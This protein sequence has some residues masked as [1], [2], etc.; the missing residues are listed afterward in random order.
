MAR[1]YAQV[2]TNLWTE[3][4]IR[5]LNKTQQRAYLL[6]LTQ[7]ELSR[8][9]V[10]PYRLKRLAALAGDDNP[11]S[12]RKDLKALAK[13]RHL[14]IDED[15]EEILVRTYVRHDGLLAQPQIVATMVDD[16]QLIE[17]PTLRLAF[18]AELRRI[19]DLEL[20]DNQRRGLALALGD[21]THTDARFRAKIGLGLAP[22]MGAAF[23]A[24]SLPPFDP[25]C[26]A[27]CPAPW[28]AGSGVPPRAGAGAISDLQAPISNL[29]SPNAAAA[30]P[31]PDGP[32]PRSSSHEEHLLDTHQADLGPLPAITAKALAKHIHAALDEHPDQ[33]ILAAL[34]DWRGRPGAKPGLLPHLIGDAARRPAPPDPDDPL[35]G[36]DPDARAWVTEQQAARAGAA[37]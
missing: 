2:G 3:P 36:L 27:G 23:Q 16:Y 28:Q 33:V 5:T 21:H 34:E 7:P 11:S 31:D 13:T 15:A 22:D 29:Q 32:A 37:R 6:V 1:S 10:L 4:T 30:P 26:P 35:A 12:L 17:S 19:W 9:G 8:C 25:A 18:L 24:G 20:P 14:V